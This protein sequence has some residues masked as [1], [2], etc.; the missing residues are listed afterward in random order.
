MAAGWEKR[1]QIST[2]TREDGPCLPSSPSFRYSVQAAVFI[3]LFYVFLTTAIQLL[4]PWVLK[5]AVDDLTAGVTRGKLAT[6]GG[7]IMAIALAGAVP[8]Y[9]MRLILIGASRD[10]EYDI[11][12]A[13]FARLLQLPLGYYQARRTGT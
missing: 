2:Y 8:G 9:Y 6:Y 13:F 3:G 7:L 5:H 1:P 12:N 10:V 11:R 4:P